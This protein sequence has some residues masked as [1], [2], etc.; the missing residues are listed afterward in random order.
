MRRIHKIGSTWFPVWGQTE[1]Q[2]P[3]YH[4]VSGTYRALLFAHFARVYGAK[5]RKGDEGGLDLLDWVGFLFIFRDAKL[6]VRLGWINKWKIDHT[7]TNR[8]QAISACLC[9]CTMKL[10][11][12]TSRVDYCPE[13]TLT[14]TLLALSWNL[15]RVLMCYVDHLCS[16]GSFSIDIMLFPM[17]DLKTWCLVFNIVVIF[18][19]MKENSYS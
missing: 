14:C 4:Y 17:A 15:G 19:V 5:G 9:W 6:F 16:M 3:G 1:M 18:F 7:Q 13:K 10:I 11:L 2:K 12:I 8:V